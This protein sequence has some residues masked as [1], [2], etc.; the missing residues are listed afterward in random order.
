M[1]ARKELLRAERIK[2]VIRIGVPIIAALYALSG[3]SRAIGSGHPSASRS[4]PSHRFSGT[5]TKLLF[6]RFECLD[7]I[8][9]D[10]DGRPVTNL[11]PDETPA[12]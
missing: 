11:K 2:L 4:K 12:L 1:L 9:L 8:A 5:K 3:R 6:K 7:L 10:K